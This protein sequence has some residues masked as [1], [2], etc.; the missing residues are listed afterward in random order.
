MSS[1][2]GP[3][4]KRIHLCEFTIPLFVVV[5]DVFSQ[6]C[7]RVWW[8]WAAGR[9]QRS[10]QPPGGDKTASRLRWWGEKASRTHTPQRASR[11]QTPALSA[12]EPSPL[13]THTHTQW[14]VQSL[15][16]TWYRAVQR[17]V[18]VCYQECR[19]CAWSDWSRWTW[20]A[21][22]LLSEPMSSSH[23]ADVL[24]QRPPTHTKLIMTFIFFSMKLR[25]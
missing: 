4:N 25:V 2:S 23:C 11:P 21:N 12:Q 18:C 24:E 13:H 7:E 10:A 14:G 5:T 1:S 3:Y 8:G 15:T 16:H 19:R 9:L 20:E 22:H 6:L 17:C